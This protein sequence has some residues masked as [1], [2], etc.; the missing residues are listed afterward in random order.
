MKLF[1]SIIAVLAM[2]TMVGCG[3]RA[4]HVEHNGSNLPDWYSNPGIDEAVGAVGIA[5]TSRAGLAVQNERAV[6]NGTVKLARSLE[7]R[8]NSMFSDYVSEGNELGTDGDHGMTAEFFE[9]TSR[10]ITTSIMKGSVV[11]DTYHDN[12]GNVYVWVT[13]SP[14]A[15]ALAADSI[16]DEI[17]QRNVKAAI[18]AETRANESFDRLEKE[19]AKELVRRGQTPATV[20]VVVR[21][22]TSER[23]IK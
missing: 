8:V 19:V 22:E 16:A 11:S 4:T 5:K 15:I 1:T 21:A 10:A 6:H 20:P 2:T 13:L 23:I 18:R 12:D 14:E 9:S 7:V 17:S 3:S